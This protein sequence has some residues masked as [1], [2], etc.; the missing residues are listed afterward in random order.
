[1][2]CDHSE[3]GPIFW[4]SGDG[5]NCYAQNIPTVGMSRSKTLVPV[6]L[7]TVPP[8]TSKQLQEPDI[9]FTKL[10]TIHRWS[11]LPIFMWTFF[12]ILPG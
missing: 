12:P 5:P 6:K 3:D 11:L 2:P 7:G 1:V 10:R 8:V 9:I 4:D